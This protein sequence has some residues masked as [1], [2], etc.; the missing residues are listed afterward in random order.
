MANPSKEKK[1]LFNIKPKN[2]DNN[3]PTKVKKPKSKTGKKN[4][5][6]LIL[7]IFLSLVL[8]TGSGVL[9]YVIK[10]FY[11]AP[12]LN[13]EDF[14]SA[15]S[16]TI[17]DKN[18]KV[19]MDIGKEL[20]RNVTY[21]QIPESLIDAYLAIEDSRFFTHNGFD[22]P[23]FTMAILVNLKTRDFSQGGSTFTMQLVKNTYF[24]PGESNK[25]GGISY[26]LQQIYLAIKADKLLPKERIFE[27]YINQNNYGGTARGPEK[28]ALYYFGKD[29]TQLTLAESAFLA[30]CINLPNYYNPYW[31][32][33]NATKRRDEVLDLM[34][35]HGYIEKFE[36]DLA[37]QVKMENL[38]VGEKQT[39]D[40]IPNQAYVDT[41]IEEV[42]KLTGK[43]P[44]EV[45]MDIHT[46]M[47]PYV[48]QQIETIQNEKGPITFHHDYLDTA[49][50]ALENATGGAIAIG[51]GRNYTGQRV[52]NIA[53]QGRKQPGS[54]VKP[55]LDYAL[56]FEYL[57]YSTGH[58][59][60]DVPIYYPGSTVRVNNYDN[61]YKGHIDLTTAVCDSRNVP[62]IETLDA[63]I[64]LIGA[65]KVIEY[66]RSIGFEVNKDEFST[67]WGI[68]GGSFECS[69]MQLA[70]AH[71]MLANGGVYIQPH[72]I[73]KIDYVDG[74]DSF[75]PKYAP[76]QALSPQAAYLTETITAQNTSRNWG[77]YAYAQHKSYPVYAKTGTTD[78]GVQACKDLQIPLGSSK[79]KWMVAATSKHT[80]A[81]WVGFDQGV[82]GKNTYYSSY[83]GN[84]NYPGNINKYMLDYVVHDQDNPTGIA[85]P[86]GITSISFIKGFYPYLA[87]FDGL[88]SSYI[89]SGL[90]KEGT[91]SIGNY[92]FPTIPNLASF[93]AS[94]KTSLPLA[95]NVSFPLYPDENFRTVASSSYPYVNGSLKATVN[96][97]NHPT[98]M[99]GVANYYTY[100]MDSSNN[101]IAESSFGSESGVINFKYLKPNDKIKVCGYY[102]LN[103]RT[104]LKSNEM[105]QEIIVPN[106]GQTDKPDKPPV[107]PPVNP[108][109]PPAANRN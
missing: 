68:G 47:D 24:P 61:R 83:L 107:D 10:T 40:L 80:I 82:Q 78:W 96:I 97:I 93:N 18:G 74:S 90:V 88:D 66:L 52:F 26:K 89:T 42:V 106:L 21:D 72:T 62:A 104:S 34:V 84:K 5:G 69:P 15:Q 9:F 11:S 32:L 79:D 22:V 53:T 77:N 99:L 31:N 2:K 3:A 35:H 41:V 29:I 91:A 63:V 56:A 70:G 81:T 73:K 14:E 36:A 49:T 65:D 27:L 76:V 98:W 51:G 105:C 100:V 45:P 102:A 17:Y 75:T 44:Y 103:K 23:R 60:L 50:V 86:D 71:S 8:V 38:L 25:Y 30:G 7:I 1:P 6:S 109:N 58:I 39:V 28:A 94:F 67:M 95:I 87:P 59:Y 12:P 85:K 48:Q 92:Q 54:T 33:D 101:I 19:I 64:N 43:D 57:G 108:G 20:R 16:S 13:I 55:F 4:L 37:K 46:Y